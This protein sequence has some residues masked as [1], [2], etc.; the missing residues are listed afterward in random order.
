MIDTKTIPS[1]RVM[2]IGNEL[3]P[4]IKGMTDLFGNKAFIEVQHY[5]DA[6]TILNG[7][8]GTI[9]TFRIVQVPEMLHWAGTGAAVV[10]NPG[11]RTTTVA[12]TAH[13]DIYPMLVLGEDSWT[14]IGFQTDGKTVKFSVMTEL[15]RPMRSGRLI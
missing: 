6:G 13:Y 14:T 5:A 4:V 10:T 12:G 3:L 1:C 11:Y 7:E 8:I 9:D 2:F 15:M